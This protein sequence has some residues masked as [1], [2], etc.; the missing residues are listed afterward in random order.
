[1]KQISMLFL[2]TDTGEAFTFSGN[3]DADYVPTALRL[4]NAYRERYGLDCH[5]VQTCGDTPEAI[6]QSLETM[7]AHAG[8]SIG[9][10]K[11]D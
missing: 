11:E 3:D 5:T 2:F 10:R 8:L 1:M 9:I 6:K 7:Y 4:F